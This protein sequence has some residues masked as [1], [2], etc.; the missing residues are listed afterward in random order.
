[1]MSGKADLVICSSIISVSGLWK[2][3]D[4]ILCQ[5]IILFLGDCSRFHTHN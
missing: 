4:F 1:M 2:S 3:V 5:A